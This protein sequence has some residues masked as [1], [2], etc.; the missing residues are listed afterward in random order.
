MS[1]DTTITKGS[2]RKR[3]PS[4]GN[5]L[6]LERLLASVGASGSR[7]LKADV[8]QRPPASQIRWER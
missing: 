7:Q 2:M 5:P 6:P 3:R 4:P 8:R 1:P